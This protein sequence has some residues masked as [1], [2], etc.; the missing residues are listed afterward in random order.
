MAKTVWNP[1]RGMR[2]T[3]VYRD[4][5]WRK[6]SKARLERRRARIDIRAGFEPDLPR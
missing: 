6:R 4:G 2:A 3:P 5:N 1:F